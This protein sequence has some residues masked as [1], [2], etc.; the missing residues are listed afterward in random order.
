MKR[1]KNILCVVEPD[2]TRT[3][4][5]KRAATLA[6]KNQANLV[7][8]S[9]TEAVSHNIEVADQVFDSSSVQQALVNANQQ[10]LESIVEPFLPDIKIELK[11][12][13]GIPF[14]EIIYQVLRNNHDLVIK[15]P[16]TA[17]WL[18]RLFGSNDMHLLRKCPCPIW[19]VKPEA[20]KSYGRILAA[21]DVDDNYPTAEQEKRH[22]M[23]Q[24]ILQ[25]AGSLAI[26]ELSE[27]HVVHVWNP[28]GENIMRSGLANNSEEKISSYIYQVRRH[29]E[30]S[31]NKLISEM[32]S[33]VGDEISNQIMPQT[34]LMKGWA[35]EEIPALANQIN[36]DLVVMGT[37]ART[38]IPGLFMGNTAENILNQLNCSVLAVK[39]P[40]FVTPV[41]L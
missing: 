33:Y 1:F 36:A 3:P 18:D 29:H 34:H 13:V 37:V 17:D 40:G 41:T 6:K 25:L 21:V 8:V 35:R 12:L 20:A 31:L 28:P 26:T 5:L 2:A 4:A 11:T 23:N 15:A 30:H 7:V 22:A 24:L 39:P 32:T 10:K 9:V 16:E 27:L 19:L 14:L 38:G